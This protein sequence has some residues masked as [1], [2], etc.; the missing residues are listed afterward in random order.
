MR[1]EIPAMRLAC[2]ACAV[3]I[4]EEELRRRRWLGVGDGV[5]DVT[6]A[7]QRGK[8]ME[9]QACLRLKLKS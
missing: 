4:S 8:G 3:R 7:F 1:L 6:K 9:R 2:A 5:Y